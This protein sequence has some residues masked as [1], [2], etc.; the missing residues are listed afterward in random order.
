M[1]NS[2]GINESKSNVLNVRASIS[3][4]VTYFL[5][6]Q[7]AIA[8]TAGELF[9]NYRKEKLINPSPSIPIRQTQETDSDFGAS[10]Q[11]NTFSIGLQYFLRNN[12]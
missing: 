2:D 10:L 3:P 9:Y 7:W 12:E 11:F 4:G 1:K 8:A 6:R 5:S